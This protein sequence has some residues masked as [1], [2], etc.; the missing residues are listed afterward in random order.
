LKICFIADVRS[1]IA[2]NWIRYFPT[3]GHEVHVLATNLSKE[4]TIKHATI[5]G[6]V[7]CPEPKAGARAEQNGLSHT[8]FRFD[9]STLLGRAAFSFRNEILRPTKCFLL[10]RRAQELVRMIAP[11]LLHALRIP[12]EG[13]LG[14]RLGVHPFVT[15]IWGNDLTL[16]AA[17]SLVHRALTRSALKATDGLL[18]DTQVDIQR[19]HAMVAMDK[20]PSLC[21]PGC[22]GLNF[23]VF[24]S[25]SADPSVIRRLGLDPDRPVVLNPR[26]LRQYVRQDTF[27]AAIPKVL[28]VRPE[29]QFVAVDLRGWQWGEQWIERSRLKAS[30]FLTGHLTQ[31]EMAELYKQ[32]LITV[33]PTEHDGTP[34]SLLEALACGCFPICGNLPSIREWINDGINGILVDPSNP[35]ALAQAILRALSD[36]QWRDRA[37]SHNR[38]LV[39]ENANYD[40]CMQRADLFY[41]EVIENCRR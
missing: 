16:Y 13:E 9:P 25:G 35:A 24:N 33:S 18:A 36:D 11:D 12:I 10:E 17:N 28:A 21:L 20:V 38:Q 4:S 30:V 15:S 29:V 5:H 8:K 26:G 1:S 22:G 14:A 2:R 39:T 32:A 41:Q 7:P 37:A 6:L 3:R 31:A 40:Q 27:F 19:A 23:G 34:N